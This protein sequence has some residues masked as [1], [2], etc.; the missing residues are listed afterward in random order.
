MN[1]LV[2]IEEDKACTNSLAIADGTGNDKWVIDKSAFK[3]FNQTDLLAMMYEY[4][5][6]GDEKGV[7]RVFNIYG[8]IYG[9]DYP[10]MLARYA[11]FETCCRNISIKYSGRTKANEFTLIHS[12]VRHNFANLNLELSGEST[13]LPSGRCPDF[14]VIIDGERVPVECKKTFTERSLIQL[15]EYMFE[16]GVSQGIAVASKFNIDVTDDIR[17]L[18]VPETWS[19]KDIG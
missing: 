2:I 3:E 8:E 6:A 11:V 12:W 13:R 9:D 10:A 5:V 14:I 7:N 19:A 15:K 18:V 17:K 1:D 16:M 4:S